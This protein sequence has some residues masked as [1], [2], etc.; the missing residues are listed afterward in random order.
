MFK[1]KSKLFLLLVLIIVMMT[2][3]LAACST[4][5]VDD[6]D[7]DDNKKPAATITVN[8]ALDM[9]YS[10]LVEG[11]KAL[12]KA[13]SK[14]VETIYTIYT[15]EINY[16]ITYK[17]YY[18]A[19]IPDS[20][21]YVKVFDNEEFVDRAIFY[22]DSRDLYISSGNSKKVLS[23][24]SSTMMFDVFYTA[25][26]SL[27]MTENFYGGEVASLF[28]RNNEKVNLSLLMSVNNIGYVKVAENRDSLEI[29]D[30]DLSIITDVIGASMDLY[31][32]DIGDKFDILTQKYLDFRLSRLLESR[33]R[34]IFADKI[35]V[36]LEDNVA[37][38]TSWKASGTMRDASKYFVTADMTYD[39]ETNTITEGSKFVKS[40]FTE[41]SLG[42]NEF[43]GTI[44]I[45]AIS[46]QLFD[47]EVVT[48]LNSV[49]NKTNQMTIR[50]LDAQKEEFMGAYYR[51]EIMY[52]DISGLYSWVGGTVDLAALR[53]P[54]VYFENI[55]LTNLMVAGYNDLLKAVLVLLDKDI[56]NIEFENEE[57]YSIIMEN[58][59]SDDKNNI[60]Y[61]I[62]EELIQKIRQDDKSVMTMISELLD[63]DQTKLESYLGED[64]FTDAR[65]VISYNLDTGKIGLTFYKGDELIVQCYLVRKDFTTIMFPADTTMQSDA[66]SKL[67]LPDVTTLEFE[68][69]LR[70]GNAKSE[71]DLSKFLGTLVG[72]VS[73]TNTPQKLKSNERLR[74]SGAISES[75]T[76]NSLG[77]S[78]VNNTIKVS[79]TKITYGIGEPVIK[80][81]FNIYT[82]IANPNILLIEYFLPVGEYANQSPGGLKYRISKEVLKS[83]FDELL[84]ENNIFGESS[85][86]GILEMLL[87]TKNSY[88]TVSKDNGY[89][90]FSIMVDSKSD[91]LF[92]LI[93]V[94]DTTATI[95]ARIRFVSI[96]L[97]SIVAANYSTPN[98]MPL[99]NVTVESIYSENSK[100]KDKVDVYFDGIKV[101]MKP[102]YSEESTQIVTGK[103]T[104]NPLARLFG[105][106]ITYRVEIVNENGTYK[107]E[108]ILSNKIV[109]DPTFN[110]NLPIQVAVLYDNGKTGVLKCSITDFNVSNITNAGYNLSGFADVFTPNMISKL[111]IGQN[112]IM[113]KSFEVYVLVNNRSIIAEKSYKETP[114]VGAIQI[115]PYSYALKKQLNSN[116]NPIIDGIQTNGIEIKFNNVYGEETYI[117]GE[118][119]KVRD[120]TYDIE[121]V[122]KFFLSNLSLQWSYDESLITWRGSKGYAYAYFGDREK[123][124]AL[125][126]AIEVSVLAQEIDYVQIDNEEAGKY[127]IDYLIESSYTLP[128]QTSEIHS[129]KVYFKGE[130]GRFR[131]VSNRPMGISDD[132]YYNNYLPVQLMWEGA[133]SIRTKIDVNGTAT[134]FGTSNRTKAIFGIIASVGYQNVPLQVVVPERYMS[135]SE[136]VTKLVNL[137]TSYTVDQFGSITSSM[138]SIRISQAKF[139]EADEAYKSFAIN[140]YDSS[141]HLPSSIYLWVN[142][143]YDSKSQRIVKNYPVRW[144]TT[145]KDGVELNIIKEKGGNFYLANPV[146][147][148]RNLV[149]YGTVGD[150]NGEI[151]VVM[152]ITNLA[153]ELQ[154]VTYYTDYN[155]DT[156]SP[157]NGLPVEL[158]RENT[159]YI[160]N[161][162]TKIKT[163]YDVAW[164][165]TNMKGDELGII[166][167]GQDNKYFINVGAV[168]KNVDL[169][170]YGKASNKLGESFW[171]MMN[172]LVSELNVQTITYMGLEVSTTEI[173]V[174]PY[175]PY[176]LP[177]GFVAVLES[178]EE[179][180]VRN[181]MWHI[182]NGIDDEWYPAIYSG[183]NRSMY[184][185]DNKYI[186][187]RHGGI[188]YARYIIEA[189]DGIISQELVLEINVLKRTI[190]PGLI[191][192]YNLEEY[193][194]IKNKPV[195]GYIDIDYYSAESTR[196]L[197]KL[198]SIKAGSPYNYAG[199]YFD[200]AKSEGIFDRF[201]LTV[202]WNKSKVGYAGYENSINRLIYMLNHPT[203]GFEMTLIGTIATG[204][205]NEQALAID[206]AFSSLEIEN[207]SF[208]RVRRM[209]E[210]S[211]PVLELAQQNSYYQ[212]DFEE[213]YS[214]FEG[215]NM[216]YINIHKVFAL[217]VPNKNNAEKYASPYDYINYLLGSVVLYY[218]NGNMNNAVPSINYL[219]ITESD[220]NARVLGLTQQTGTISL[221]EIKLNKLSQGSAIDEV[222]VVITA[223]VDDRITNDIALTA[224]LYNEDSTE[225]YGQDYPLPTFIDVEYLYSGVVRYDVRM[226][227]V[228]A[229]SRSILATDIASRI[230][231]KYIDTLR[232]SGTSEGSYYNFYYN[233]PTEKEDLF[234]QV[235]IPK[236]NIN[237]TFYNAD[238]ETTLYNIDNGVINI[239]NPYQ[240][241]VA[242]S[243]YGLDVSLIPTTISAIITAQN[244]SSTEI[245]T[246]YV[247]WVFK[248][249]VFTESIFRTGI[250]RALFATAT[251][252]CYYDIT[253]RTELEQIGQTQAIELYITVQP[254]D[255]YGISYQQMPVIEGMDDD[256]N[257]KLNTI[258]LDPYNDV[259]HY[260]GNLTLPNKGLNVFFNNLG[261]SYT[262]S[263]VTFRL[264]D[265]TNRPR[266][267]VSAITYDQYGHTL[268]SYAY[269][270][271]P[272]R[273]KL[274]MYLPGYS[275][276]EDNYQSGI[277]IYVV[278]YRRVVEDVTLPNLAT[279]ESGA[280]SQ[281][282]LP[283]LYFIDPYNSATYP[284]PVVADVKFEES[285]EFSTQRIVKWEFFD[286][287]DWKNLNDTELFYLQA[288]TA[289]QNI[290]YGYFRNT[291]SAYQGGNYLLRGFIRVGEGATGIVGEQSF[292]V[293]VIV[294][295]R[296]LEATYKT[297]HAFN[298][299]LGGILGDVPN[300]LAQIMFVDYDKYYIGV[301]DEQYYYSNWS[302]PVLPEIS[303][304]RYITDDEIASIG[305]F[306]RDITGYISN[307]NANTKYLYNLYN[308][309][310]KA[311][312]DLLIK[313]LMWDNYFNS[314]GNPI[315]SY[316][317]QAAA[318]LVAMNEELEND[319]IFATYNLLKNKLNNSTEEEERAN[320]LY[321]VNGLIIL[322]SEKTGFNPSD[323]LDRLSV[324]LYEE[325]ANEYASWVA[326]GKKE[327]E[328]N[329]NIDIYIEWEN[330]YS[331]FKGKDAVNSAE[332]SEYQKLKVLKYN[333]LNDPGSNKFSSSDRE[334]NA[335][336]KTKISNDLLI[337]INKEVY[338]RLYDRVTDAERARMRSILG[339]TTERADLISNALQTYISYDWKNLSS[340][341]E[342]A[343]ANIS[344]PAM[345][346]EDIY[347]ID[348]VMMTQAITEFLFNIYDSNAL[349][350]TVLAKFIISYSDYYRPYIE[351]ALSTA[352]ENYRETV[353]D[354][355]IT[356]YVNRVIRE[357]INTIVPT[358]VDGNGTI[359]KVVDFD[360]ISYQPTSATNVLYWD[361]IYAYKRDNATSH[362]DVLVGTEE[363]KW[364]MIYN[365]HLINGD[366]EM[367]A[368]MD[369]I[370]AE[371]PG[372][373]SDKYSA[374]IIVYK[375]YLV[376]LATEDMDY[377]YGKADQAT[378]SLVVDAISDN[379]A[380]YSGLDFSAS[381]SFSSMYDTLADIA[382]DLFLNS[383]AEGSDNYNEINNKYLNPSDGF[384]GD[385]R[386]TLHYY[387]Y[388]PNP[389]MSMAIRKR[390]Q[391]IF[392]YVLQGSAAYD[393]MYA[394]ADKVG[395]TKARIDSYINVM[396]VDI[397]TTYNNVFTAEEFA[398]FIKAKY[399]LQ[400]MK[401]FSGGENYVKY[402]QQWYKESLLGVKD[403]AYKALVTAYTNYDLVNGR[404][405]VAQ[406]NSKKLAANNITLIA[407]NLL[408][409]MYRERATQKTSFMQEKKQYLD[410]NI[411]SF[412][413]VIYEELM[414]SE[415]FGYKNYLTMDDT[416]TALRKADAVIYYYD[417]VASN[418]EKQIIDYELAFNQHNHSIVYD[419]LLNRYDVS[420]S[421]GEGLINSYFYSILMT[422]LSSVELDVITNTNV[423]GA[424]PQYVYYSN[425][426]NN[427]IL[428]G[429][430]DRTSGSLTGIDRPNL[431]SI[432]TKEDYLAYVYQEAITAYTQ[433]INASEIILTKTY[434]YDIYN[435]LYSANK[436]QFDDILTQIYASYVQSGNMGDSEG[437]KYN[438]FDILS[439]NM[440]AK[441]LHN[442][443]VAIEEIK[444]EL[445]RATYYDE[446]SLFTIG[447]DYEDMRNAIYDAFSNGY[448]SVYETAS[449]EQQAIIDNVINKNLFGQISDIEENLL[450]IVNI[451]NDI[452]LISNEEIQSFIDA[453]ILNW[454]SVS[455]ADY[456]SNKDKEIISAIVLEIKQNLYEMYDSIDQ[457]RTNFFAIMA[458]ISIVGEYKL[459][460]EKLDKN[461]FERDYLTSGDL[462][463]LQS[464]LKSKSVI[465]LEKVLELNE[466][467]IAKALV[468]T[469]I[470]EHSYDFVISNNDASP[471]YEEYEAKIIDRLLKT[472][473]A[474]LLESIQSGGNLTLYSYY[475]YVYN[476]VV[477][478]GAPNPNVIGK[479][480]LSYYLTFIDG[481]NSY[482]DVSYQKAF[483]AMSNE[484]EVSLVLFVS[485]NIERA[486]STT[487]LEDRNRHVLK[488][489]K[490]K[491]ENSQES[492]QIDSVYVSNSSKVQNNNNFK[493]D[494]VVYKFVQMN[495]TYVDY[496]N[497]SEE[498]TIEDYTE[499]NKIIIDPLYP[500]LPT[501]VKA[502]ATITEN[503]EIRDVGM[504]NVS[505]SLE[506]YENIYE[507]GTGQFEITLSDSRG[508]TNTLIIAV[509]YLDRK[510]D[511]VFTTDAFYGG[512]R[513]LPTD[514]SNAT[515]IGY[516]NQ[517]STLENTNI[518]SINP[519]NDNILDTYNKKFILPNTLGVRFSNGDVALYNNVVWDTGALS[520]SLAEQNVSVRIKS[521]DV[522]DAINGL[523]NAVEFNYSGG[524]SVKISMLNASR[525][526]IS[527]K[528]YEN[529]PSLANWNIKVKTI[530]QSITT[531]DYYDEDSLKSLGAMEGNY[532]NVA[533]TTMMLNPYDL[534]YPK[535]VAINFWDGTTIEV[536]PAWRLQ[537]GAAGEYK[538]K[539]IL[540]GTAQDRMI[541]AQFSYLGHVISVRF[542]TE[543]IEIENVNIELGG[544][545]DG[546]TLYLVVGAGSAYNQLQK[547]YAYMY[548]NF[549][550]VE[551]EQNW[552]KVP[553]S[554]MD[555]ELSRIVTTS[556]HIY[557]GENAIVGVLGWDKVN[558]PDINFSP[559]IK[560]DVIVIEPKLYSYFGGDSLNT[561]VIHDYFS[562]PYDN[563]YQKKKDVNEPN[564]IGNYFVQL[565]ANRELDTYFNIIAEQTIYKV[566]DKKINFKVA[567]EMDSTSDKL[568][569]LPA[570]GKTISFEITL[571]LT[572]YLYTAV[573]NIEF[574][575]TKTEGQ[576]GYFTW[577]KV[578]PSS[579]SYVPA[580][581][582]P[583]GVTLRSSEMPKARD[584]LSG[585]IIS[586]MWDLNDV[587]INLAT[588]EGYKVRGWYYDASSTWKYLDLTI[589]VDKVDKKTNILN[590]LGGNYALHNFYNGRYYKLPIN[591]TDNTLRFLRSDGTF[592]YLPSSS[593]LIEYKLVSQDQE[594]F[595]ATAY[596]L[597]AG[598]Y[599]IKV[600]IDDYNMFGEIIFTLK[601]SAVTISGEL[602]VFE[603]D[604]ETGN[605]ITRVYNGKE[606]PLLVKEGLPRVSV[607]KWFS[608]YN[609]K[610]ALVS[611]YSK[612]GYSDTAAKTRAYNDLYEGVTI[613]T[614]RYLDNEIANIRRETD[615]TDSALLN[616]TLFDR[617][618]PNLQ[619]SEV[620]YT[621]TYRNSQDE[622]LSVAPSDVGQYTVLFEIIT[623]NNSGNYI[624]DTDRL[625]RIILITKPDITYSVLSDKIVYSGRRQNPL[626][627]NLHDADGNLPSG[628]V[629]TYNYSYIEGGETK[630]VT[631]GVIN[632]GSYRCDILIDGGNNYPSMNI[633]DKLITV[634]AKEMHVDIDKI[635]VQYLSDV[636]NIEESVVFSGLVG[637]DR[638]RDFGKIITETEVKSYYTLG[639]YQAGIL[640]FKLNAESEHIYTT[641]DMGQIFEADGKTYYRLTLKNASLDGSLYKELDE[642]N[643][644]VYADLINAFHN[645][646]IYIT[647][648]GEY[649]ILAEEDAVVIESDE[650]LQTAI[651]NI[652]ENDSLK[653]YL[654]AGDYSAITLNVNAAVTIVGCYDNDRNI[655]TK[656][657]GITVNAGALTVKIIKFEATSAGSVGLM[658]NN[659]ANSIGIYDCE[660]DGNKNEYAVAIKTGT[661][662]TSKIY[663]V[664]TNI[665]Y[666]HRGVE[667]VNGNLE[668]DN[669]IFSSNWVG[670]SIQSSQSDLRITGTNFSDHNIAILSSNTNTTILYNYFELN[671][672]GIRIPSSGAD[673]EILANNT[674]SSTN[675][676]NIDHK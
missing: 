296:K 47:M 247:D 488:L 405:N 490:T 15:S 433:K 210:G 624:F 186:F 638:P 39:F 349:D 641:F 402:M 30:V 261:E 262:F 236:K 537:P 454:E 214:A 563:N 98:A 56:G 573:S 554:F 448:S 286:G 355:S 662:Y 348:D 637:T 33:F 524:G 234:L 342:I 444:E 543:D 145:N 288:S 31:L 497:N 418:E 275:Y 162:I 323:Y 301:I 628:V 403:N 514:V 50:I 187:S 300:T 340:Y 239:T 270:T 299:P 503:N 83:A 106:E 168:L 609:E 319:V 3:V 500:V 294:L 49:D 118:E 26:K 553:L 329:R 381:R 667:L 163:K 127:T 57:L 171:V 391:E 536:N 412:A 523:I 589:F 614:K 202:D 36:Q 671:V 533:S 185:N 352:W 417:N 123:G 23:D 59:T 369:G 426:I 570:G 491:L 315:V 1:S 530:N 640:G 200:E 366:T 302:T 484:R 489:D 555:V 436:E 42:K 277:V 675:A 295:N 155:Y 513:V 136:E 258:T 10:G 17:A 309:Q 227:T 182:N 157:D 82:N 345:D 284:L 230:P 502:Y 333:K 410:N 215:A 532:I 116:Y 176:Y 432:Y 617:L 632:V 572:P 189:G 409:E 407:F 44:F 459:E 54:K 375:K 60:Y 371:I 601:I 439:D 220:F 608:S 470:A 79:V 152:H 131:I 16:T 471:T 419:I 208:N 193:N 399:F 621:I 460:L 634:Q 256:S 469:R 421:F 156:Y 105:A 437:I 538:L 297:T 154:S 336:L 474:S 28:N 159:Y 280:V 620:V 91:P 46:D 376:E 378:N 90:N 130:T 201:T 80:N 644:Y 382:F 346:F 415:T 420:E 451:Y 384:N 94:K 478:G 579:S 317:T 132:V 53:F 188:Y 276:E 541:M 93:G 12:E 237:K 416:L 508:N 535:T 14:Y 66:Y 253:K 38:T 19:N 289:Y 134:L 574:L 218:K 511:K 383:Y 387:L 664:D 29:K 374:A 45:P 596:P 630:Y 577:T 74:I 70:V 63:V 108:T 113:E 67:L 11:G 62:T 515:F 475:N 285:T 519:I 101:V 85:A 520:Y 392:F 205:I 647:T 347:E 264:V 335:K 165:T 48:D 525:E 452:K 140:P 465:A 32:N 265:D 363:E 250:N 593:Y 427:M 626:I 676:T 64:F 394:N 97:S 600:R 241:Y 424:E 558:Y 481:T 269:L 517:F 673:V 411:Y 648:A 242:D 139:G 226:W 322:M 445:S 257:I 476:S 312:Y 623:S 119:E 167:L 545:I 22:Y 120:L 466:L 170:V 199:V 440:V 449:E 495:I 20:L 499:K 562:T 423:S 370:L 450:E 219:G 147:E 368:V 25:I 107:I 232:S 211:S 404:T 122:N 279:N 569:F 635:S 164:T 546:G 359:Q 468:D 422:M 360:Y 413:R 651:N 81:V 480:P 604:S 380:Q 96:D 273:I 43:E 278:I 283:S 332:L 213:M 551:N 622:V 124:N 603:G 125:K 672:V 222:N 307:T 498:S 487:P 482:S 585:E 397:I 590:N 540:L 89:I 639:L 338:L 434:Y 401:N 385:K 669:S 429:C 177:T 379:S 92:D 653:L 61:T 292:E 135:D 52:L 544:Y 605:T 158:F 607:D 522:E 298:D 217:T 192:I 160:N 458:L 661:H 362:I 326:S 580:I 173:V 76:T 137:V 209:A 229:T 68:G 425:L 652:S 184:G 351:Q 324:A 58:F 461:L 565:G 240:Y 243:E 674:F 144:K 594:E 578:P 99:N 668:M 356:E 316:S 464:A 111:K 428:A 431:L 180:T 133:E 649:E 151:W 8:S 550:K 656:I 305:G 303:W 629:V 395:L 377:V 564:T 504:V 353:K 103:T 666:Y 559:N 73:G 78:V 238:G 447:S 354:K 114:I 472:S 598:E 414:V 281:I 583:L 115:D 548:Y 560:F 386:F 308:Q 358:Y 602:I 496:F 494:G 650:Q 207:I 195:T 271:D 203:P 505:Y 51:D 72:D 55:N 670:V 612:Q 291:A 206:F 350:E 462:S 138:A 221:T 586:L 204:T 121:G 174:D 142:K 150:G 196:L 304:T 109:V 5:V 457:G 40:K 467:Y 390:A 486:T 112:S 566:V 492:S 339:M 365:A 372:S 665:Y 556:P 343:L 655:L 27:D 259:M 453:I 24:F 191:E 267:I 148:Q 633:E 527:T 615:I 87:S 406:L 35:N 86:F 389:L 509:V 34:Y 591:I 37:K 561:Y 643:N 400:M 584:V 455:I 246:H 396:N 161:Q 306:D 618:V 479:L 314:D 255:F 539:D 252:K 334:Y 542:V 528:I 534:E 571:N 198:N 613:A 95:K 373:V 576:T 178:G 128:T 179:I 588:S 408:V 129:V 21:F 646:A 549:S 228:G 485:D 225:R 443:F 642:E 325:L 153:S 245:N 268:A 212:I 318:E 599:E 506:F 233:L 287:S 18:A 169:V 266:D 575:Q 166:S 393:L 4:A 13:P 606:H 320:G 172:I 321:L 463:G 141:A 435:L 181:I 619:I 552:Q 398:T 84:G 557:E 581:H 263:D 41:A 328:K 274:R 507:G 658:I 627:N 430:E 249:D 510:I 531:L 473:S 272:G 659:N 126:I 483:D 582:W 364:L 547:N 367:A 597:N 529:A 293:Q 657:G 231:V 660:F 631:N 149:V 512:D 493:K 244:Y 526:V 290:Q 183:T 456:G 357:T 595:S 441:E 2:T 224:E 611:A 251:L 313:A 521:Y 104:Y 654:S 197:D 248:K 75:I 337:Y 69:E 143:S 567:Y 7:D 477:V 100:W 516:F 327:N 625:S 636:A 260:N 65:L 361:E 117:D 341:G 71:T 610:D 6:P 311:E 190:V 282:A 587:N 501:K 344:A 175:K 331:Q 442:L 102:N 223:K 146:T 88:S 518:L 194:G 9:I 388:D 645:Y 568:A 254:M 592:D 235:Y 77:E 216:L 663:M 310:V 446:L 330:I 616:A 438:A 110:K